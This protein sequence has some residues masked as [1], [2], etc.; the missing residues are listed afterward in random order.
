M[1]VPSHVGTPVMPDVIRH[2]EVGGAPTGLD[3]FAAS[4][5]QGSAEWRLG[6]LL[7]EDY[8]KNNVCFWFLK[9]I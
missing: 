5:R 9:K 7:G 1:I 8:F 2:P 4:V 6:I 3:Q